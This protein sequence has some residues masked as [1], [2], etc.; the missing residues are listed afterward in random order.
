VSTNRRKIAA[1][2]RVALW[3]EEF[4]EKQMLPGGRRACSL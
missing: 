1:R 4:L 2:R 3:V